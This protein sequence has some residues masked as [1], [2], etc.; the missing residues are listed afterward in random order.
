MK[1]I[2]LKFI[3]CLV[4]FT[5]GFD[6]FFDASWTDIVSF[7]LTIALISYFIGDRILLPL[8]GNRNALVMDFFLVYGFVWLFG[9]VLF[10]SYNQI[11]WG[12]IISAA[13]ITLG[14]VLVHR[15]VRHSVTEN[16][17]TQKGIPTNRLAYSMEMADEKEPIKKENLDKLK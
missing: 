11:A 5:I 4:A 9:N 10:Q 12:S 8:I 6:L 1:A 16:Q 3:T 17:V 14:E 7:S 2:A 15:I 13:I